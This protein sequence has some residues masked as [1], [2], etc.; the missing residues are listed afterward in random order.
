MSYLKPTDEDAII[1]L[2]Y[3]LSILED[4][5]KR[6]Q[7]AFE[8]FEKNR[9]IFTKLVEYIK[10][11]P[12]R[13]SHLSGFCTECA[14]ILAGGNNIGIVLLCEVVEPLKPYKK[15]VQEIQEDCIYERCNKALEKIMKLKEKVLNN[16]LSNK[17]ENM[18][19]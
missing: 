9:G 6:S 4:H 14:D 19:V 2:L 16:Y 5:C 15:D 12:E 7:L 8:D 3:G 17:K 10:G 1:R 11:R 18:K 13:I